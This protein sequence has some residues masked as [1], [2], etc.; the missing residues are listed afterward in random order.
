MYYFSCP[1]SV[2]IL[3]HNTTL[4]FFFLNRPPPSMGIGE[5]NQTAKAPGFQGWHIFCF[6]GFGSRTVGTQP[7]LH[8]SQSWKIWGEVL[9]KRPSVFTEV[10]DCVGYKLGVVVITTW[11][12]SEYMPQR[13]TEPH[14]QTPDDI[15]YILDPAMPE[16]SIMTFQVCWWVPSLHPF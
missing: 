5:V 2:L 14:W 13:K 11:E 15:K 6:P 4:I 7:G 3:C 12:E 16:T 9:G 8:Q 1:L 10:A